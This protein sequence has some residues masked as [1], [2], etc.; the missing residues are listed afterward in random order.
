[1]K[2]LLMTMRTFHQS[3]IQVRQVFTSH[4]SQIHTVLPH[5]QYIPRSQR[6]RNH[7]LSLMRYTYPDNPFFP[8]RLLVSAAGPR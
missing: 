4:S 6:N 8:S 1:M 3:S 7:I 5:P 2:Y